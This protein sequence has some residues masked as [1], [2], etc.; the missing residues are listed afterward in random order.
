MRTNH[1]RGHVTWVKAAVCVSAALLADMPRTI[2]RL[3]VDSHSRLVCPV[4]DTS[5]KAARASAA[6]T[7]EG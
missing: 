6:V 2:R 7:A 3:L 1:L 5:E 4:M